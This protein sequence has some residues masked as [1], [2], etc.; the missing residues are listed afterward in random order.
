ML[1]YM[2]LDEIVATYTYLSSDEQD[3]LMEVIIIKYNKPLFHGILSH[4]V[5]DECDS[6]LR[7][8]AKPY[9]SQGSSFSRAY[10]YM[11]VHSKR[12]S[13]TLRDRS[14]HGGRNG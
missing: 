11:N 12:K 8:D 3:K 13:K 2:F 9:L 5:G 4:W 6:E 10:L 14:I 7:P 1:Q